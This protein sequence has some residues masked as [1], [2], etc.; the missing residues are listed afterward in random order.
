MDDICRTTSR[1]PRSLRLKT[2]LA[3][4][5]AARL[6]LLAPALIPNRATTAGE[7]SVEQ[8]S[9]AANAWSILIRPFNYATDDPQE[10][11]RKRGELDAGREGDATTWNRA[12][13]QRRPESPVIVFVPDARDAVGPPSQT[14]VCLGFS[15]KGIPIVMHV[16]GRS[17]APTFVFGAIHGN[18]PNSAELARHLI[19]YLE[20]SPQAYQDRCIAVLA[21]A[22][23]DGLA[24]NTRG[25]SHDID[26]NR[27]F[28]TKNWRPSKPGPNHGGDRPESEPET[29]ALIRA[30]E[31]L[32]P[33]RIVSIH[34]IGRGRHGNNFDGPAHDL[35]HL[36]AARNGYAVLKNMGYPTPGSFGSWA[37]ID[38]QI[39]TITLELPRDLGGDAC[40]AE[41]R[42]ALLA[43]IR[44]DGTP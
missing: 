39:P 14:L 4:V 30:V 25:N 2:S 3:F 32:Q 19:E 16:F 27:N 7:P 37:G 11:T 21:V 33:G 17:R 36:M 15:V 18:E 8:T 44:A 22:N 41:N 26:L 6:L 5:V 10:Y 29:R 20:E 31:M 12:V 43:L 28:S 24:R 13:L 9:P 34:A 35:A 40:W 38:R 23:P 1:H 42:E